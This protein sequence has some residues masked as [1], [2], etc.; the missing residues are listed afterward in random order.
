MR[1]EGKTERK[2]IKDKVDRTKDRKNI[3]YGYKRKK[4]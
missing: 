2:E 1:T 3:N 4:S